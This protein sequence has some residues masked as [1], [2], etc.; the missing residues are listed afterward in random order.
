MSAAQAR[1]RH[2]VWFDDDGY[3]LAPGTVIGC[4][5]LRQEK[6]V[7]E[8]VKAI[9]LGAQVFGT[10]DIV[11]V[12]DGYVDF[13]GSG[14]AYKALPAALRS[15]FEARLRMLHDGRLSFPVKGLD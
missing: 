8:Q 12:R 9:L 11:G 6:L 14:A 3:N 10:A 1:G 5:I 4:A 2:V 15:T 7:Y 13:D